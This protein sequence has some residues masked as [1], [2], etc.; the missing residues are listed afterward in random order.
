[1]GVSVLVLGLALLLG[2]Q[3]PEPAPDPWSA[4]QP[5]LDLG[6]FPLPVPGERGDSLVHVLR[7]DPSRFRLELLSA[8][9]PGQGKNLTAREWADAHNLVAAI[10]AGMFGA[11]ETTAVSM[12]KSRDH[13]NNPRLT[14]DKAVLVFDPMTAEVP[15]VQIVDREFQDFERIASSYRSFV[16]SIRMISLKG[17]NVWSPQPRRYSNAALAI[18]RG[19]KVL[20]IHASTPYSTHDLATFLLELPLG[21]RN[22]MYL[23]GGPP[24]QLF[25]R[26]RLRD[27]EFTGLPEVGLFDEPSTPPGTPIPNVLGIVAK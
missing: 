6:S 21:I 13:V 4:L 12:L 14:R 24:A 27:L 20:F 22:A 3:A 10:N 25:V 26:T 16:Q 19:G 23:E 5:G 15:P 9:A 2:C 1:M 18:D 7:I 11:D 17:K 8:S